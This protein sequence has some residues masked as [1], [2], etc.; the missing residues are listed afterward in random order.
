MY[1]VSENAMQTRHDK[2]DIFLEKDLHMK[3]IRVNMYE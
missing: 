2:N 1:A 3:N